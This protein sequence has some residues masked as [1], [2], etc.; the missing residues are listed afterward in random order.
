MK[1][2]AWQQRILSR[3]QLLSGMLVFLGGC[4]STAVPANRVPIP[5]PTGMPTATAAATATTQATATPVPPTPT[6]TTTPAPATQALQFDGEL[7]FQHAAE[8]MKWVP[9][10]T[11]T[12]GWKKCG[13]YILDQL[14]T[15]GWTAEEQPFVYM[16]TD[17]RNLI[18]KR[19]EGPLLVIGAHYDSRRRADHDPDPSKRDEPVPAANDGA[20]GVAILLELARVLRP[21]ELGRTIWLVSFDAEDNGG[22]DGWDWI[23]GSTYFVSA[24]DRAVQGMVL[25]DMIGDADQQLYYERNSHRDMREAIWEVADELEY[26]TFIP[27]PRHT[28]LDDH[29]P[30]LRAGIPAV[31]IIDFDYPYW[32]TTADTLDKISVASL[33]AVGRTLEEW[34]LRDAPGMP[35]LP[36]SH[37]MFLPLIQCGYGCKVRS[38]E[39]LRGEKTTSVV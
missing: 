21:E 20:S 27:R 24:L 29:I 31:D 13:D 26:A 34:L 16:G 12:E 9:R 1:K 15:A 23:A 36:V 17:C 8:Q 35:S 25:V 33:E 3:R 5:T 39:V 32:H 7:A 6:L 11:G 22:L 4:A 38:E 19:G 37:T 28:M 14:D 30:F 10:H 18:G 2:P